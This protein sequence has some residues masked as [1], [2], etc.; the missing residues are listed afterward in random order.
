MTGALKRFI[1][2]DDA[3]GGALVA[4][5][6][7][8]LLLTIWLYHGQASALMVAS[9]GLACYGMSAIVPYL[10]QFGSFFLLA[11]VIPATFLRG[12]PRRPLTAFGLGWGGSPRALRR[13]L[14]AV[15]LVVAPV[16]WLASHVPE[17]RAAYP[18]LRAL[19]DRPDLVLPYEAAYV[20]VYY[21]A[22]EFF[23]RGWMLFTLEPA[24]GGAAA[25]LIQTAISCL[26]HVGKPE[27]EILGAI[28][29][30]IL[31]GV[32]ALRTRSI[33]PTLILHASLGVLTDL[34][35]LAR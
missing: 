15:P 25:V 21:V 16:A 35:I 28:P 10:W 24:Y 13:T 8:P 22:W 3:R 29:V 31:F 11:G 30:G 5:V 18:M 7:A 6:A 26:A 23:F 2:W 1:G 32:I 34:L 9:S 17:V 19:H 12:R 20:F 33:W 14:L 4:L 27:G